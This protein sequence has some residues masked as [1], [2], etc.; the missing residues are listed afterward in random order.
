MDSIYCRA[1][2]VN[3]K[4]SFAQLRRWLINYCDQI[5]KIWHKTACDIPRN[6]W[7]CFRFIFQLNYVDAIWIDGMWANEWMNVSR[8][9]SA[10]K[11]WNQRKQ[12]STQTDG[13]L[14]QTQFTVLN[15]NP[16]SPIQAFCLVGLNKSN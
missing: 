6:Y 5:D 8:L 15:S 10:E 11:I 2:Y 13:H 4:R 7:I 3:P 12:V 14:K 1:A 16:N 9:E